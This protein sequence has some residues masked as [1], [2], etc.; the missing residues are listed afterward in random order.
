MTPQQPKNPARPR[1]P[2]T[3]EEKD[4]HTDQGV[5]W[6]IHQLTGAHPSAWNSL[7]EFGP[8]ESFR[9]EPHP[10]TQQHHPGAGVSYT[11][12]HYTTA[13]AEVFQDTRII[14]LSSRRTLTGW[15]PT[16]PLHLLDLMPGGDWALRNGAAASLPYA[17]KNICRNWAQTIHAELGAQIDGLQAP[18]TITSEPM[19]VL[20]GRAAASFPEAPE[21]S[22]TLDHIDVATLARKAAHRLNWPAF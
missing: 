3:L 11:A 16:R 9:W 8:V 10:T 13:F 20:F 17:P 22:R 18:S 15:I 14:R 7:R 19:I 1:A 21:F 5:L 12:Q 2:L 6:R 4:L